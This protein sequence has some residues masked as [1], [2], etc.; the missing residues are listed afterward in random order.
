MLQD[1][2]DFATLNSLSTEQKQN[3]FQVVIS[4]VKATEMQ[5]SLQS[6]RDLSKTSQ[7]K[8]ICCTDWWIK[9]YI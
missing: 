9:Y 8:Q 4:R 3:I 5:A 6:P 7:E 1:M 2:Q